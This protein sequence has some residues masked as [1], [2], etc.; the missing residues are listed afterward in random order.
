MEDAE[1][2]IRDSLSVIEVIRGEQAG[3][4]AMIRKRAGTGGKEKK[5]FRL[6]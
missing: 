3:V 4:G 1:S 5:R 6:T 2:E